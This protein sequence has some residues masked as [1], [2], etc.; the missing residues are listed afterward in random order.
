MPNWQTDNRRPW[1]R[2]AFIDAPAG[3]GKVEID[4]I[5]A[6]KQAKRESGKVGMSASDYGRKC[7]RDSEKILRRMG[8]VVTRSH[9]SHG[10]A[11]LIGLS[12][13]HTLAVQVKSTSRIDLL[14]GALR[15]GL[16]DMLTVSGTVDA[17]CEVWLYLRNFGLIARVQ[18][19]TQ[20]ITLVVLKKQALALEPTI[21]KINAAMAK[22]PSKI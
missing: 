9:L 8:Y 10:A 15:A 19:I 2:T 5:S 21:A 22:A 12:A 18:L 17:R 7:E 16:K 4:A 20:G 13:R 11:D 3:H 6:K 1:R 14:P